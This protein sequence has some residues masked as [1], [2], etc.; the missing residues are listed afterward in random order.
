[1]E[2]ELVRGAGAAFHLEDFLKAGKQTPVFFGSGINNFGVREILRALVDWA[3]PP[4]PRAATAHGQPLGASR[5]SR[6]HRLRVQDPGQHG[7]EPPRPHRLL[8]RLLGPVHAGMKVKQ[9]RTGKE[10]KIANAVVFMANERVAHGRGLRRRHH[11]HPQPRP[12]ADRRRADRRRNLHYKGIPY[13]APD[14][15]SKPRLRDPLKS[16]Q[17]QKGLRE[18]GEEG[19]IQVF[20]PAGGQQMLLGAVGQLQFEVVEHRLKTEYG[21][22]AVFEPAGIHTARWVTFPD[23]VTRRNFE[24]EQALRLGKDIDG[25]PVYLATSRYNLEVTAEKWPKVTF[26]ATREHGEVL[27]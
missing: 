12:A 8:P 2:V 22:D 19:A 26:H 9:R 27:G 5:P 23:D 3:P 17:L 16:K 15:F 13:F 11:R 21:V 14:L 25:N 24:R 20:A 4:Q 1:M 18:L 7:P 6:L 10:I